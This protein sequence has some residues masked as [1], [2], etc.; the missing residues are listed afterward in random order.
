MLKSKL[1][2]STLG[3]AYLLKV[4]E[5]ISF[6]IAAILCLLSANFMVASEN[7]VRINSV[8]TFDFGS[9]LHVGI[10]VSFISVAVYKPVAVFLCKQSF[11]CV[12]IHCRSSCRANINTKTANVKCS[13]AIIKARAKTYFWD[14]LYQSLKNIYL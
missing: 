12:Y 5:W 9:Q 13:P 8:T 10:F 7:D 6:I 14:L 1:E 11:R 3:S 4:D 2:G